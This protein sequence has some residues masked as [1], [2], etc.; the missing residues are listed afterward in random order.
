MTGGPSPRFDFEAAQ[1]LIE[2]GD[3]TDLLTL[4][5]SILDHI[6]AVTNHLA[7]DKA[8]DTENQ[9]S[10][11]WRAR[12]S[13]FQRSLTA[14]LGKIKTKLAIMNAHRTPAAVC[15]VGGA[16]TGAT[17][18]AAINTFVA[19]GCKVFAAFPVGPDLV[20]VSTEPL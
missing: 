2:T 15:I 8:A 19:R 4:R 3:A 13:A 16:K 7:R 1:L 17:A 18:A 11:E 6:A 10:L 5:G 9:P 20:V 12:A 14:Y